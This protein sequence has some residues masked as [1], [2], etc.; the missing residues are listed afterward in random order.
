MYQF[1]SW[2][3]HQM[4]TFFAL[5]ALCAGNSLVTGEFPSQMPVP[6]SLDDCFD[7]HP[8]KRLS[9]QSWG[10]WF[11]TLSRQ[12]WRHCNRVPTI[13]R[14]RGNDACKLAFTY[15]IF[16]QQKDGGIC[17]ISWHWIGIGCWICCKYTNHIS[18]QYTWVEDGG[19][20]LSS[21][22]IRYIF[23]PFSRRQELFAQ[24]GVV[25]V[26]SWWR[27]DTET[28][29]ALLALCAVS[30]VYSLHKGAVIWNVGILFDVILKS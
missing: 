25:V 1:I 12:L 16:E 14:Y 5:L 28:F 9:K 22:Y 30:P 17:I 4:E 29:A 3:R 27:H 23:T 24:N 7:L 2:W 20:L 11:E 19:K 8:N 15:R 18:T 21:V 13:A 10:W 26:N 6:R